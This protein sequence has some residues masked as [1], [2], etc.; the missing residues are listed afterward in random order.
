MAVDSNLFFARR[1]GF[2]LKPG[3]TLPT[4]PREWAIAQIK[5]IPPLDFYGKDGKSL[6]ATLPP[7]AKPLTDFE[8]ACRQWEIA[9]NIEDKAFDEARS[10]SGKE[11]DNYVF[12]KS[13]YP[14]QNI[15]RWRGCLEK[16]LTA[17][18][19]P[20]PVFERFWMFWLNHFTVST[21]EAF[22]KLFYGAHSRNVRN[23][24]TGRFEDMLIDAILNPA[25]IVYLDNNLS[26]GPNSYA[27]KHSDETESLNENLAR[28][29]LEL[30]TMSPAG[31]YTQQ[32]VIEAALVLTGW[33]FYGGPRT[34]DWAKKSTPYGTFFNEGAHEPGS[35]TVLGKTY[36]EKNKGKNQAPDMLRDLAAH[37]A[38]AKHIS[39]KLTRHF[40]ADVPPPD[41]VERIR[42]A[43][44]SSK[45]DLV[46][47]HTAVIDE[48]LA[49]APSNPK[50]TTPENWLLQSFVATGVQP[51]LG[52]PDWG[53]EEIHWTFKE[54][55]QSYD[56][57][58][59]P[60]GWSDLKQD[61]IS[62]EMLD[63]RIRYAYHLGLQIK[64]GDVAAL[65]DYSERLAGKGSDL[66][67]KV[68]QAES[69]PLAASYLLTSPHFLK[70]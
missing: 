57:C 56:Q 24:M 8:Q 30:H 36:K 20:S 5:K 14:Y 33:Q 64:G 31:G 61:W 39:W 17:V 27:A 70:I 65:K 34:H 15:P 58:P 1:L 55:G 38:T 10:M 52:K 4:A 40:I 59:Q 41:S 37:P 2:G 62:K 21:T 53:H 54:L 66:A 63:R 16:T 43:W 19:G 51:P 6:L 22:I 47:I 7:E 42:T 12:E 49:K 28:E 11:A 35:R 44:T 50:F 3:Q 18:N 60:N 48:V 69:A 67:T 68:A 32:D 25:M 46:A 13:I 26:T 9:M 29:V 23:R 45:G